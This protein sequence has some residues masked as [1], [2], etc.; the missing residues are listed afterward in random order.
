M[1]ERPLWNYKEAMGFD[2]ILSKN[3]KKRASAAV[4]FTL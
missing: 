2:Y 1:E 4:G 3:G